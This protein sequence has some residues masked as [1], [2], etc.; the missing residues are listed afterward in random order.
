MNVYFENIRFYHYLLVKYY[1][2]RKFDIYIFDF[3]SKLRNRKWLRNLI[4]AQQ[5]SRILPNY[6]LGNCDLALNSIDKVYSIVTQ[7]SKLVKT[8]VRLYDS[9]NIELAYK[10]TLAKD[11]SDFYALQIR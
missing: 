9:Q 8:M 2:L 11:L 1:L 4:D 3:D 5:V 7:K 6:V 10:K